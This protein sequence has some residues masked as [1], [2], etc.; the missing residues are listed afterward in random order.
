MKTMLR[1]RLSKTPIFD[2]RNNK[3]GIKNKNNVQVISK[4][5]RSFPNLLMFLIFPFL[6]VHNMNGIKI[7]S[8]GKN[9]NTERI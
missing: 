6:D 9:R 4:L 2:I 3:K 7:P 8:K 1:V 5:I